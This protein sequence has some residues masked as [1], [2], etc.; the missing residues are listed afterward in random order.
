MGE[1]LKLKVD[2][3]TKRRRSDTNARSPKSG[4]TYVHRFVLGE[5]F[6]EYK[7]MSGKAKRDFLEFLAGFNRLLGRID[8]L[9]R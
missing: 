8:Q 1:K 9:P 2:H 4:A 6:E 5:V 3:I 7:R